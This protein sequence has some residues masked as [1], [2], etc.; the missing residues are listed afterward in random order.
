VQRGDAHDAIAL[1]VLGIYPVLVLTSAEAA[2]LTPM[3]VA[4]LTELGADDALF[5]ELARLGTEPGLSLRCDF[6]TGQVILVDA[7]S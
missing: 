5:A 3:D 7:D 4:L 6:A 1:T 2:A